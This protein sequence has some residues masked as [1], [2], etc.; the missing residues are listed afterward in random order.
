ML[1][2]KL[3]LTFAVLAV[4]VT[5]DPVGDLTNTV[6]G[7]NPIDSIGPIF[8]VPAEGASFVEGAIN[9]L[10]GRKRRGILPGNVAESSLEGKTFNPIDA[11]GPLFAV[12]AEGVSLAGEKLNKLKAKKAAL[13]G[14]V[15]GGGLG[16]LIGGGG[17]MGGFRPSALEP[18]P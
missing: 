9:N 12:P 8:A 5:A 14:G 4:F 7:I 15:M 11:I 18:E 16:G 10:P 6:S 3:I 1:L 13:L 2:L 17:L